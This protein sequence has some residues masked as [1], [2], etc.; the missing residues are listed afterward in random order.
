VGLLLSPLAGPCGA[1]VALSNFLGEVLEL[2]SSRS[3]LQAGAQLVSQPP[4]PGSVPLSVMCRNIAPRLRGFAM[5]DCGYRGNA[6]VALKGLTRSPKKSESSLLVG[7]QRWVADIRGVGEGEGGAAMPQPRFDKDR[8][9]SAA[10][11]ILRA[12]EPLPPYG[13]DPHFDDPVICKRI[14]DLIA[15]PMMLGRLN[16]TRPPHQ[17]R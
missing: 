8:D 7:E 16:R 9:L 1:L 4:M 11:V 2:G 14:G 12:Q 6:L 10:Y 3:G 5:A 17:S 13:L 15:R